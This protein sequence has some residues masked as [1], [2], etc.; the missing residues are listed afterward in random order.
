[1]VILANRLAIASDLVRSDCV[2]A[3]EFPDLAT[4]YQ[5]YGVPRTVVN[6][7]LHIEGAVPEGRLLAELKRFVGNGRADT[8]ETAG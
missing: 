1:M 3:N 8:E 7:T 2:E 5:V 4:R 6:E